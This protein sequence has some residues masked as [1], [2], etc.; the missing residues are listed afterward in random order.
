MFHRLLTISCFIDIQTWA[1]YYYFF[2]L[3]D[4]YPFLGFCPIF[5]YRQ[6]NTKHANPS[7]G[8]FPIRF[9]LWFTRG[10]AY[11]IQEYIGAYSM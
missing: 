2:C 7:T 10:I 6:L 5:V 1:I 4:H 8:L 9:R 3:R 11:S